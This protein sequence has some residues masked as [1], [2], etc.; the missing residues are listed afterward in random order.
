M[1]CEAELY[2]H[3]GVMRWRVNGRELKA[4]DVIEVDCNGQWEKVRIEYDASAKQYYA[5]PCIPL[6]DK[7]KVRFT[8]C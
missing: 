2:Y 7:L 3:H 5:L 1:L 8:C 6:R 4:G